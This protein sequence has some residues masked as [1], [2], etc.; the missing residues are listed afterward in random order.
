MKSYDSEEVP[1]RS[2][3]KYDPPEDIGHMNVY[4]RKPS[5]GHLRKPFQRFQFPAARYNYDRFRMF[6]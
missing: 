6:F 1:Y 5:R 2:S 3:S 4:I